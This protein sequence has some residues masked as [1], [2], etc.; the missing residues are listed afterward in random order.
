MSKY[1]LTGIGMIALVFIYSSCYQK[2]EIK[3]IDVKYYTG[4]FEPF[5]NISYQELQDEKPHINNNSM[6]VKEAVITDP[7]VLLQIQQELSKIDV[8]PKKD[9]PG[10]EDIRIICTI[11]YKDGRTD[12]IGIEGRFTDYLTL[13]G[14]H[15][16]NCF[17]LMYLIKKS[18]GYYSRMHEDTFPLFYELQDS[19]FKDTIINDRGQKY[20]RGKPNR[21][22]PDGKPI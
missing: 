6:D 13:N 18:I 12:K 7:Q 5:L 3:R 19:S 9:K 16:K 11:E 22:S 8:S 15:C 14:H 10:S 21:Y 2:L 1:A 17:R 20:W 4:L